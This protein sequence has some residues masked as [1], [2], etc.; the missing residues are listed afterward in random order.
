MS[1]IG[2]IDTHHPLSLGLVSRGGAYQANGATRQADV[3][4]AL[5]VRFD[6]RTSSSW[7]PGYSFTIPPTKLIH[8]DID[9]EEIGRNYPVALGLMADVRTFLRQVLAE[10]DTRKG[11]A[12]AA[13]SR[14]EVARA[15]SMAAARNGTSS[16]RRVS[17]TTRRRSIRS[18]PR[19]RSTRR[20][21][22]TPSW[23]ATSACITTGCC[24]SAS[25]SGRTSSSAAWA[26]ARWASASPACSVRS[27]PRRTGPASRCAATARSSCTPTCSAPRSNTICRWSGW[28]G[29]ITPMRRSA[30][31][32]AAIWMAASSPPTS[33]I[34]R[35]ASPTTRTSRRWRAR[36]ASRACAST[37]PATSATR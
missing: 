35:P 27:S 15:R 11:V 36:P 4:L 25:R 26:S 32:S 23:S 3:L 18:A 19:P 20:C 5:G 7:I 22:T 34:P 2:A 17:S 10:L 8:V 29:T 16:S 28:S 30:D 33:I 31:C 9:P 14:E 13:A 1:G 24:S 6:D 21:P 37:A 12:D